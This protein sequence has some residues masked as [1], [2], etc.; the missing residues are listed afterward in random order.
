MTFY[1]PCPDRV[2]TNLIDL[3]TVIVMATLLGGLMGLVLELLNRS[4]PQAVPG[5]Q[6]W[7][8]ATWLI[9]V[10]ALLF[11]MRDFVPVLVSVTIANGMLIG[12]MLVYLYGSHVY[13]DVTMYWRR[14]LVV[15][16]VSLLGLSWFAHV[17]P[18]F[19]W[20]MVFALASM[21]LLMAAHAWLFF[22][23][24]L[25]SL[26]RRFTVLAL[27]AM[28]LVFAVRWSHAVLLPQGDGGLYA[29]S[30]VQTTYMASYTVL[31]LL[32][33]MGF[34]LLASERMREV[35]EFQATHDTLT[36]AFNRR[37]LLDRVS[38]ELAR[39]QRY[40]GQFSVLMLDLDHFKHVND[41]F[42]HQTGD[43]VLKQ[44]VARIG[45]TLRPNDVLGRLGGEEFLVLL[46]E[47]SA[48]AAQATADRM[49]LAVA[50]ESATLPVC[51]ASIGLTAW[52]PEDNTVDELV[53]RADRAMY[54][55]KGNGR[56][57]VEVA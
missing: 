35:F 11:A 28:T 17:E 45:R 31:L 5:L 41:R 47:T 13:F 4:A 55:A 21:G 26:G 9:F 43:E 16:G 34:V 51:T 32:I 15:C 37:A 33:S 38:E 22:R 19:R 18:N 10:S 8:R 1:D 57:R 44:F 56:N 3:R 14:W 39:S 25:N 42:G 49:L 6:Q 30:S 24:P 50:Q 40:R 2:L 48:T 36:G 52:L 53:A 20:R 29:P 12:A 27:S 7:A 54:T 46:P 23:H